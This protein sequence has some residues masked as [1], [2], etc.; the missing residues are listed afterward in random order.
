MTPLRMEKIDNFR[1]L[2]KKMIS[3]KLTFRDHPGYHHRS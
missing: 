2:T 1:I 3:L